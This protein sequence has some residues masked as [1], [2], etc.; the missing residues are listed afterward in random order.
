MYHQPSFVP[1]QELLNK[2]ASV[3]VN[4]ALNSGAGV[5]KGEVVQCVVP[6]IAKPMALA[7]HNE[8]LKSGAHPIL[9]L[10]PTGFDKHFYD[11][12]NDDQL[13]FF[14]ADHLKSKAK[15]IDHHISIIAD[16][17]PLE[18]ATV[19]SE[20]IM[21][22]RNSKKL[23]RDWLDDKEVQGKFTWTLALW[24]VDAK[25]K[26]VGLSLKDYWQQIIDACFLD[27]E[28]P[29]EKWKEIA[30]FQKK[31]L[32]KLN[33][34]RID[35][36]E[37]KGEDIDLKVGLGPERIWNGGSG[38]NIP[39]FEFFTSPDWRRVDGWVK[40][41][42][43]VYRYGQV[44]SD[45]YLKV[46]KGLIIEAKAKK[47]NKFLQEMLKTENADKFGEFSLTD[48][49][50][51]RITHSMAET[52]FDENVGGP[53]GNTHLAIGKAYK[54]CY[55]YDPSKLSKEEWDKLGYNDSAEHTDIVS[56]SDRTVTAFLT[57][58]TSRVIYKDGKFIL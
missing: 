22:S 54:D 19:A 46:E 41:N 51:S 52:L 26:E 1:S 23:Y 27:E 29:I 11:L 55:R 45:V 2:Y 21:K 20:K 5:K 53:F 35:Y 30:S 16:V 33:E 8:L 34:L 18:L 12:A 50:T 38:R 42:Q 6:D 49:R 4:F 56:T 7:L 44:I 28:D 10:I 14:P 31:T 47:G 37:V 25:A 58:G 3:L 15:L 32:A 13:V 40:F 43:P 48:K 36:L 24:G 57:D 17:D 39:S 9:R